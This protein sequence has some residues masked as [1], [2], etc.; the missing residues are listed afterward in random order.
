[1]THRT[2]NR[3]SALPRKELYLYFSV[4]LLLCLKV[5]RFFIVLFEIFWVLFADNFDLPMLIL[6][7]IQMHLNLWLFMGFTLSTGSPSQ[8]KLHQRLIRSVEDVWTKTDGPGQSRRLHFALDLSRPSAFII[9][10][11]VCFATSQSAAMVRPVSYYSITV[12][13]SKLNDL[14][15]CGYYRT[16]LGG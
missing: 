14:G 16:N 7:S 8:F 9:F 2:K 6:T 3:F 4:C 13:R 1:M 15:K 5:N 10:M 12:G 11:T